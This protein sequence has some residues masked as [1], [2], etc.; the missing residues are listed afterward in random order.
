M[1]AFWIRHLNDGGLSAIH[2][3]IPVVLVASWRVIA[4]ARRGDIVA[5]RR[6]LLSLFVGGLLI[7][8]LVSFAPGRLMMLW[9]VG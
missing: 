5:H 3:L 7:P 8:A 4:T 1:S 2:L 6:V 9:L